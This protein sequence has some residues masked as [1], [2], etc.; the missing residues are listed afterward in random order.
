M[1]FKSGFGTGAIDRTKILKVEFAETEGS[2]QSLSICL[3][4]VCLCLCLSFTVTST[5]LL[6]FICLYLSVNLPASSSVF[7]RMVLS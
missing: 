5:G 3:F 7:L 4:S 6:V 1:L 2:M